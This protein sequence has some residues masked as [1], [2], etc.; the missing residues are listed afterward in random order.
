MSN[1]RSGSSPFIN[2]INLKR[3]SADLSKDINNF[4]IVTAIKNFAP[5]KSPGKKEVLK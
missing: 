2:S 1:K 4:A 3:L 5:Q